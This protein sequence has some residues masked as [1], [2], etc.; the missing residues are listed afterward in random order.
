MYVMS[1]KAYEKLAMISESGDCGRCLE[2]IV[3]AGYPVDYER[4]GMWMSIHSFLPA[5]HSSAN[6]SDDVLVF[7]E[8][9]NSIDYRVARYHFD[10]KKWRGI[11]GV[12]IENITYW[13]L[14]PIEPDEDD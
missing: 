8:D 1:D 9:E 5:L 12:V 13:M 6:D 11:N 10:D 2:E 7:I 3:E 14:L 4:L